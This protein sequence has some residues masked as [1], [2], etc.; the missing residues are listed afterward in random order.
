[1]IERVDSVNRSPGMINGIP[2]G[3]GT[4]ITA[5]TRPIRRSIGT[6]STSPRTSL[7]Y[8]SPGFITTSGKRVYKRLSCLAVALAR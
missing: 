5:A 6:A 2:G 8:A 7:S 1:M 3:Y 4:S